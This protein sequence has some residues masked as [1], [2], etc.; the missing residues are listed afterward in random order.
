[1]AAAA[2]KAASSAST[3]KGGDLKVTAPLVQLTLG[4]QVLHLRTGDV[5]PDGASEDWIKH[6][7][8]L[9]YVVQGDLPPAEPDDEQ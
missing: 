7:T 1:M 5:V 2:R 4:T 3:K 8:D 6:H 9:G